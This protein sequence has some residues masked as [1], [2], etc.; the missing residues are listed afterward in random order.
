MRGRGALLAIYRDV[1]KHTGLMDFMLEGPYYE[2]LES[3]FCL[4]IIQE[5]PLD[6][7]IK[8]E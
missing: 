3:I 5:E 7:P 8:D 4:L 1:E 2:S 6:E